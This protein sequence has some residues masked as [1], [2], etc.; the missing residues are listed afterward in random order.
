MEV[1]SGYDTESFLATYSRCVARR[2]PCA[3]LYSDQ[4]TNF[5]GADAELRKMY[6]KGSEFCRA[7][8]Q[9][10]GREGTEWYFNPPAAPHFG[11]IWEAAVKSDKHHL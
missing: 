9:S 8:M 2:G 6:K 10:V 11:G 7:V 4:G 3:K 1:V 5:V